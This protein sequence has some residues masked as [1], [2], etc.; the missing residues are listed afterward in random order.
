[1]R[2][3]IKSLS[4]VT[5]VVIVLFSSCQIKPTEVDTDD[6]II[7]T[8]TQTEMVSSDIETETEENSYTG[9]ALENPAYKDVNGDHFPN[10]L[11]FLSCEKIQEI[12]RAVEAKDIKTLQEFHQNSDMELYVFGSNEEMLA[13]YTE[14]TSIISSMMFVC[15][16]KTWHFSRVVVYP[17]TNEDCVDIEYTKEGVSVSL[18]IRGYWDNSHM[19]HADR[20]NEVKKLEDITIAG[21]FTT[22]YDTEK[23]TSWYPIIGDIKMDQGAL[24]IWLPIDDYSDMSGWDICT[25]DE[26][27]AKGMEYKSIESTD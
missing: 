5:I 17:E 3:K 10:T 19:F 15:P 14:L 26:L 6:M 24:R 7:I 4:L 23:W 12:W 27:V 2:L 20:Y 16:D 11:Y 22:I 8:E 18:S 25:F 21:H 13:F 1:M 9:S